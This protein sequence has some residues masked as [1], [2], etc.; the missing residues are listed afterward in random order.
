MQSETHM[1]YPVYINI[2]FFLK[3]IAFVL[4]SILLE[5]CCPF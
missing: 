1:L 2:K 4:E 5:V 3:Q